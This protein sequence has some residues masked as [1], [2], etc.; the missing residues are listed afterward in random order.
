MTAGPNSWIGIRSLQTFTYPIVIETRVMGVYTADWSIIVFF[1]NTVQSG[2]GSNGYWWGYNHPAGGGYLRRGGMNGAN[3]GSSSFSISVPFV[4][5]LVINLTHEIGQYNGVNRVVGTDVTYTSGI[6]NVGLQTQSAV[7]SGTTGFI[8]DWIRVRRYFP[9]EPTIIIGTEET[10]NSIR[11]EIMRW[12]Y[13]RPITI[14]NTRNP[15]SLMDYQILIDLDT[16]SLISSGKMS[17]NCKDIRFTD[18]DEVTL[19]NYWI[20]S[21]CN[22]ANTKV[23]VEVPRIPANSTKTIY[24]LYGNPNAESLSEWMNI[25]PDLTGTWSWNG[26]HF[27]STSSREHRLRLFNL[28]NFEVSFYWSYI[29]NSGGYCYFAHFFKDMDAFFYGNNYLTYAHSGGDWSLW[30]DSWLTKIGVFTSSGY[31]CGTQNEFFRFREYGSTHIQYGSTKCS[32]G[33]SITDSTY[34]NVWG[35]FV[36][37]FMT[38]SG[39]TIRVAVN[40]IR[41]KILDSNGNDISPTYSIG[42]EESLNLPP[43]ITIYSPINTTYFY[44]NNFIFNFSV[45]DDGS[46][47][48]WIK[49]FLDNN[50]IYENTSY[51]NNTIVVLTQNLIQVKNYN[52]TIW[53]NDTDTLNSRTSVLT[54]IFTIKDYEIQQIIYNTDVYET[55]QQTFGEVIRY[56]PDLVNNITAS[57]V[58][59]STN[60]QTTQTKNSTHFTLTSQ[61]Y[62]PLV[63]TNN[64]QINFHFANTIYYSNGTSTTI[65]SQ[66]NQQNILFAYV[67]TNLSVPTNVIEMDYIPVSFSPTYYSANAN[68]QAYVYFRNQTVQ[69]TQRNYAYFTGSIDALNV[70]NYNET[71]PIYADLVI[72]FNNQTVTRSTNQTNVTVYK[73]TLTDCSIFPTLT[74]QLIVRDEETSNNLTSLNYTFLRF[75]V[76]P[77][78]NRITRTYTFE[79][80][81]TI[82]IYPAWTTYNARIYAIVRKD[83]Y[84]LTTHAPYTT[85]VLS[86]QTQTLTLYMLPNSYATPIT[87]TL[88]DQNYILYVERGYGANFVYIRS[89]SADFNKKVVI[90]LRPYDV[91]YKVKVFTPEQTLCFQSDQFKVASSTYEILSCQA[92]LVNYTITPMYQK[93]ISG[94]CS[95]FDLGNYTRVL[96]SFVT[97]D[98]LDH[99]VNL[100]IYKLVEPFGEIVYYRNSTRASTGSFDVVLE[101]GYDYKVVMTAHSIFDYITFNI[102]SKILQ[103]SAEVFT[104]ALILF[105]VS[106]VIGFINPFAGLVMNVLILLGLSATG[107]LTLQTGIIGALTLLIIVA[108][109]FTREWR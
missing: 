24:L 19:L 37:N 8:V 85:S 109:I 91:Y 60:Y 53:A 102:Y 78:N 70:T 59:N 99:D 49:A 96:C 63:Q 74:F 51:Q 57:L 69:L 35:W 56:N 52:F 48:F 105:V 73:V 58:W 92:G 34:N 26:S 104:L 9:I 61:L 101:K 103:K 41:F 87:F 54:V 65:N 10:L 13:K 33:C 81:Q 38:D 42:N 43:Q 67:P 107:V 14:N 4:W 66:T 90:Y 106:A 17:S 40:Q 100:T 15:N 55:T 86:N 3:I 62:I 97:L 47:I 76:T 36:L 75:D 32:S 94:N 1:G 71:Y 84:A 80:K 12:Q 50:L 89:D 64:T 7:S 46:S 77:L 5:G 95:T 18:S 29:S 88:P 72:S 28:T 68:L 31:S 83:N 16:A 21:G 44:S 98:N 20:E 11:S 39:Y 22:S 45:S 93:I 25:F 2:S 108:I 79:N 23:W 27:I 6:L 82:C 30:K